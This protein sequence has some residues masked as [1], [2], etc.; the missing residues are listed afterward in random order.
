MGWQSVVAKI[1]GSR[2]AASGGLRA[3]ANVNQFLGT[4]SNSDYGTQ[5]L[6]T[7]A[8]N[9]SNPN[10]S[11]MGYSNPAK[12]AVNNPKSTQSGANST[13]ASNPYT[14]AYGYGGNTGGVSAQTAA[15]QADALAA[16]NDQM[17]VAQSALGRVGNQR[18]IG[19]ENILNSYNSA[20]NKL[21][22]QKAIAERD[23][24]TQKD[25]TGVDYINTRADIR[26]D[27]RNQFN[28]LRRLLGANGAGASSAYDTGA[29]YAVGQNASK[30]YGQTQEQFG[31]N[32]RS[33]DTAWGD[34]TRNFNEYEQQ[35]AEDKAAKE[36]ELEAGL[37][38]TEAG[39][40][41]T[42]ANLAIQRGQAQGQNYATARTA[43]DGYRSR[44][45]DLLGSIDNL[46][47]QYQNPVLVNRD[48]KYT[49]AELA[50][51]QYDQ[52]GAPQSQAGGPAAGIARPFL[53]LLG[54]DDERKRLV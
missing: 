5:N 19:R 49:P 21:S 12:P 46:G 38:Q 29:G 15:A 7:L 10:V 8:D 17:G 48:I 54:R 24:T 23:Y 33:I 11:Y 30:R 16:I 42:L 14:P 47:R 27:A 50:Q 51:Y 40:N 3:L 25:E 53:S 2:T 18:N 4:P 22:G 31:R 13:P 6:R 37:Q 45:N 41:D 43:A 28:S 44:I 39:L 20:V 1:P 9:I 52:F 32:Q 34:T 36:R 26:G 35:L